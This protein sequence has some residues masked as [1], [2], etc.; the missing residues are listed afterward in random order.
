MNCPITRS[1]ALPYIERASAL[2]M[3]VPRNYI[4]YYWLFKGGLIDSFA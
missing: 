2:L 4:V 1:A 3:V